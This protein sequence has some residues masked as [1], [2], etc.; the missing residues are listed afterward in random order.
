[1]VKTHKV[2]ALV[3][4]SHYYLHCHLATKCIVMLGV[5]LCACV[6]VSTEPLTTRIECTPH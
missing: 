6:C 2:L 1:M 4:V 3:T 5:M